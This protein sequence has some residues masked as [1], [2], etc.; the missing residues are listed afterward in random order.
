MSQKFIVDTSLIKELRSKTSAGLSDCKKALEA[1]EGDLD[2]AIE[3]LRKKGLI[4]AAKKSARV[5]AEG[6]IESYIH[7]GSKLGVMVELN[8]ETDYVARRDDFQLLARNIAMQLAACKSIEYVSIE[9]I[10]ESVKLYEKSIELE[11][12]DLKDKPE[13][14]KERIIAGRIDKRL[15]ELSLM[16]QSFVKNP[17]ISV[18]E[19]VK[20]N[21]ALL[22]ENIQVRRFIRFVLGEGIDKKNNDFAKD[23]SNMINNVN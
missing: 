3:F 2:E 8:C 20:Q 17:D 18:E 22:G 10:P 15:K 11:K 14:V 5:A 9:D 6:L 19:L 16:E 7:T 21:I 13:N 1:C 4:S 12:D 23:I